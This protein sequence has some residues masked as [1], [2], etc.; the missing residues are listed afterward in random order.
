[1]TDGGDL[2]ELRELATSLAQVRQADILVY[3]GE[4]S[5][6]GD[7]QVA[8]QH[9]DRPRR[10]TCLL[11]LRTLGGSADAG[12]RLARA[13]LRQYRRL[14]IYVDDYCKGAGMLLALAAHELVISD[15]GE[16]GPLDLASQQPV[17]PGHS[18]SGLA[19]IPVS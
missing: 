9:P 19:P 12:Y 2:R 17:T 6:P 3:S 1:M 10:T 14:T 11:M 15:F 5:R 16:L 13:L 8:L 4:L 7:G 18:E